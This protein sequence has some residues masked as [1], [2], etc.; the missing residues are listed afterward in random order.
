MGFY[1]DRV[2]PHLINCGCG[3]AVMMRQREKVVPL[4]RGVVLEVGI[5]TG[6]NLPYYDSRRVERLIGVDPSEA[7]WRLAGE[8]AASVSFP[9]EFLGLSGESIPLPAASV[10]CAVITFSLC[11][12]PDPA[13]ALREV[14]RVLRP[15]GQLHFCEHGRAPDAGVRR[16]QERL[17]PLWHR[18]MGGC[19]LNRDIPGLLANAGFACG[20]LAT[21]YLPRTPRIAG[22]NVWGSAGLHVAS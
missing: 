9:V 6:H 14:A 17:D 20:D 19:H 13:Q 8:R 12:I 4:A 5:G 18:V 3:N 21:G 15:G 2:L 11:T 10:D 16:W 1:E 22:F 7:S